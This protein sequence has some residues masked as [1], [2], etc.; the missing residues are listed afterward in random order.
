[1]TATVLREPRTGHRCELPAANG[2][3]PGA[4]ARCDECG[5]FWQVGHVDVYRT[6]KRISDK[7]AR[8]QLWR[9]V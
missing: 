6:W 5:Q 7:R 9:D 4:I 2:H 3:E 8:K 1:M